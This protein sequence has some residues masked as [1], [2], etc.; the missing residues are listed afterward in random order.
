MAGLSQSLF[1]DLGSGISDIFGGVGDAAEAKAYSEAATIA[2]QN[3]KLAA[4]ATAIQETQTQRQI[5]QTIGAQKAAVG[6]AGLAESGSAQDLLRSSVQQGN[7]Q[8][9]LV[10]TQ[11]MINVNS[12]EQEAA[13][14]TGMSK[15][16][17]AAS[18]GGFLGGALGILG[19]VASLFKL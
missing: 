19:G 18:T 15:A 12:Y 11:G 8:T 13:A 5:F 6:G 10:R 9:Q 4:S 1:S 7:L 3:A 2:G 17:T 16:A 14:Y